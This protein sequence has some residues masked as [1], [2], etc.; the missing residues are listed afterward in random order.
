[1]R[2]PLKYVLLTGVLQVLVL[3]PSAQE[4]SSPVP[5]QLYQTARSLLP[6]KAA[7]ADSLARE[8]LTLTV[9]L[10][11]THDSLLA[12]SYY[13]LGL[14]NYFRS[15]YILAA[16]Y[17]QKALETRHGKENLLIRESCLNNLGVIYDLEDRLSDAMD[18]YGQ[19]LRIAEE[20]KDS[21][22]IVQ[23]WINLSLID[24][25]MGKYDD[26]ID[27]CKKVID[28]SNRQNDSTNLGLGYQNIG[29]LYGEKGQ[30]GLERRS[31][32]RSI[33]IFRRQK[34]LYYLPAVLVNL[35]DLN[36]EAGSFQASE[37][38]LSE[39][40]SI[41]EQQQLDAERI[42]VLMSY[43]GMQLARGNAGAAEQYYLEAEK[44]ATSVNRLEL[45]DDIYGELVRVYARMGNMAQ[46]EKAYQKFK[47]LTARQLSVKLASTYEQIR[48]FYE[49]DKLNRE[50]LELQGDVLARNRQLV[51]AIV[52]MF[53]MAAAGMVI[54]YQYR[55]LQ[56]Y[57]KTLFR[58]NVEGAKPVEFQFSDKEPAEKSANSTL[59]ILP[60]QERYLAVVGLL[61]RE[62]LY[63]DHDL[64]LQQLST[65][66]ASNQKYISQA[67]NE[68]SET[69]FTRLV[70]RYRVNE[71]KRLI[72]ATSS[73][74]VNLND[75]G[76]QSG[77]NNRVSFY[78]NFKEETGFTPTEFLKMSK[79]PP[80]SARLPFSSER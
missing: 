20:R 12:K 15:K 19:S 30:T 73:G 56:R 53:L 25:K 8:L 47:E 26:G 34:N 67:I 60:S 59:D 70:N 21:F 9:G 58:L 45:L 72:L 69:S 52:V 13:L 62:K 36:T 41:A 4:T 7:E 76:Y 68:H 71:A 55:K 5:G 46:Y 80:E 14:T 38:N 24:K 43:G 1:M 35:A 48:L 37:Q 18:A 78:R 10:K 32:Q 50:K 31:Y 57:V 40:L 39:A 49:M 27:L 63:L 77:F 74:S 66:L 29:L 42:T 44:L 33:D 2:F 75:I 51:L 54:L 28:F 6:N 3:S 61:E 64:N 79:S 65:R 11:T 23:S 17:Y 22:S 16:N